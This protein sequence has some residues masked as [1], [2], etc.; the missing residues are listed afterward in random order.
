M[1]N[2]KCC[3]SWKLDCVKDAVTFV[4][5]VTICGVGSV[6]WILFLVLFLFDEFAAYGVYVMQSWWSGLIHAYTWQ[7][8]LVEAATYGLVL[9]LDSDKK[10]KDANKPVPSIEELN[11]LHVKVPLPTVPVTPTVVTVT[12]KAAQPSD[13]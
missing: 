5:R 4:M 9:W 2:D 3:A 10:L 8:V 1:I 11:A 12:P 7:F 13:V 6:C